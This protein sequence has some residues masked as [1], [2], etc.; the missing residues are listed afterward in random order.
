MNFHRGASIQQGAGL[1][2]MFSGL[3]RALMPAARTVARS[4]AKT[5][6]KIANNDKVQKVGKYIKM[7]ATRSAVDSALE[8]LE[9]K[10]VGAAAKKRLKTAT[11]NILKA[12]KRKLSPNNRG[13]G[14]PY[15]RRKVEQDQVPLFDDVDDDDDDDY[16]DEY[17]HFLKAS[18][19][20]VSANNG[21]RGTKRKTAK[22]RTN[23]FKRRK[24]E[25]D[26]VPLLDGD[27]DDYEDEYDYEYEYY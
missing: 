17:E 2:S 14:A 20:K 15:K 22:S 12:S 1:G 11:K 23:Y 16:E 18:K 27:Y 19:R 10:P 4:A 6:G 21:G 24:V 5:I 13:R 7:E 26:Q 25:E 9:G 8:A 3:F